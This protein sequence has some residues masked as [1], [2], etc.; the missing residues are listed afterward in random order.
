MRES[1]NKEF[2]DLVLSILSS[3][4][5]SDE[6][7]NFLCSSYNTEI[8]NLSDICEGSEIEISCIRLLN[9]SNLYVNA[10]RKNVENLEN[11]LVRIGSDSILTNKDLVSALN[12]SSCEV[13]V[14]KSL[15][16]LDEF[17]NLLTN[18]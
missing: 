7:L 16:S 1:R 2:S 9:T 12:N 4:D 14:T 17:N 5:E 8:S 10:L 11:A 6:E 18:M 15:L 13:D 3:I